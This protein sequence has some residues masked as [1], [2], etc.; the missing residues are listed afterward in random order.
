M[1]I[2]VFA[3]GFGVLLWLEKKARKFPK[4]VPAYQGMGK[5][6]LATMIGVIPATGVLFALQWALPFD[7]QDRFLWQ[8]GLFAVAWIA[9][10]TWS[11]YRINSYQAAREFLKIGGVLYLIS[12]F[13]HFYSSGFSPIELFNG[14]M[15]DILGVDV[16][17]FISGLLLLYVAYKLPYEREDVEKFWTKIL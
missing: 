3:L 1:T 8:K 6:S 13:I 14:G 5:L 16:A 2:S 12:P 10:F 17:L 4:G 9:T 11:F 15:G 7:M